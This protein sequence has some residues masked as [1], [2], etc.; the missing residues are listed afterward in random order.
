MS[1]CVFD[2]R[3]LARGRHLGSAVAV[4]VCIFASFW[5]LWWVMIPLDIFGLRG[6]SSILYPIA[7]AA[8]EEC[9]VIPMLA[10]RCGTIES[11]ARPRVRAMSTALV[12]VATLWLIVQVNVFF[13]L[14]NLYP[15]GR[16]PGVEKITRD[17]NST[18]VDVMGTAWDWGITYMMCIPAAVG[19][20]AVSLLGPLY[21]AL[22]EIVTTL[23][24][25]ASYYDP[26][27]RA[28]LFVLIDDYVNR[29]RF[30]I[31]AVGL[32]ILGLAL[33]RQCRSR[34]P[35]ARKLKAQIVD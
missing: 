9:L 14:L 6:G 20:V 28:F 8:I 32:L 2:V 7:C 3:M 24:L 25:W 10:A 33:W 19:L 35:L 27:G 1:D 31:L 4:A 30:P 15:A 29:P 26:Q 22:V 34:Y 18:V 16:V 21:G 11:M 13:V 23:T 5:P 12:A 17:P